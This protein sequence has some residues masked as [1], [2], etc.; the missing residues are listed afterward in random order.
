MYIRT[1]TTKN[2]LKKSVQVVESVRQGDKV[3]QRIV[4]HIGVAEDEHH[5]E[6]LKK[7][8]QV[9]MAEEMAQR[10]SLLDRDEY[11]K[12]LKGEFERTCNGGERVFVSNL[13]Y[14]EH[15]VEGFEEVYGKLF[16]DLGFAE[17][18]GSSDRGRANTKLL[19]QIVV[20]RI[21]IAQSKRGSVEWL[22]DRQMS[23]VDLDRVYRMMDKLHER[24]GKAKAIALQ[25]TLEN[26]G[27]RVGVM[28]F[29]VTTL[30]FESFCEDDLRRRGFSK[31]NK[32]REVQVVLAMAVSREGLPL[33]YEL[34]PGN[35]WEGRTLKET[36]RHFLKSF[37]P[38]DI[39]VVADAGMLSEENLSYLEEEGYSYI[40]R[41]RTR[42]LTQRVKT[43]IRDM[44]GYEA[45]GGSPDEDVIKCKVMDIERGR[46]LVAIHSE[47]KAKKDAYDRE[48]LLFRLKEI[49]SDCEGIASSKLVRDKGKRYLTRKGKDDATYVLDDAKVAEDASWDGISGIVTNM[50]VT[51]GDIPEVLE[52]Y[53]SLWKIEESF[54]VAK[55]PLRFRPIFHWKKERIE[56]HIAICYIAFTLQRH[57]EHRLKLCK[58]ESY[59]LDKVR[60]VLSKVDSVIMKDSSTGTIYR[61]PRAMSPE[62]KKIYGAVGLKRDTKPTTITSIE[63]YRNRHSL[64]RINPW[65]WVL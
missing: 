4:R 42:S 57:L 34:F 10:Q 32:V 6:E 41:S 63:K 1:K 43:C 3:K 21:A 60:R 44:S 49:A 14:E 48:E 30:Y 5:L 40:V 20:A 7:L 61:F 29:D 36:L 12:F 13:S 53:K 54:R 22:S 39:I 64:G 51:R 58:G 11:A 25:K 55:G 27:G 52:Y 8:A 65:E 18:F 9:A 59:S 47:V 50:E 62:A 16:R 24:I 19:E 28:L 2:S 45:L 37:R 46:K 17:V 38:E 23:N 15:V 31:E 56:S 26:L 33:S 35:T